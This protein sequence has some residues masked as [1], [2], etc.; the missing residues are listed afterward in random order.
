MRISGSPE[1][2]IIDFKYGMNQ[3]RLTQYNEIFNAAIVQND[4]ELLHQSSWSGL[5]DH[6]F[7]YHP[8]YKK[9][10]DAGYSDEE[11]KFRGMMFIFRK[12]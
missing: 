3:V 11:L 6:A 2:E 9:C 7:E 8:N 12:L 4:V 1:D 10:I 5:V